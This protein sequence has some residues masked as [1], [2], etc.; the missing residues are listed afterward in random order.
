MEAFRDRTI[1]IDVPYNVRVSDEVR[2]YR[3]QFVRRELSGRSVAPHTLEIAALWAVM[4]RLEDPTHPN[5][6]LLQ[7][8]RLY[9]GQDVQGFGPEHVREMQKAAEREGMLGISPRYVQDRI[10]AALVADRPTVSPLDVLAQLEEG[11]LHH[12][13]VSN[14]DTRR[15]YVQLVGTAREE[16][17]EIIKR[18]VQEAISSDREALDRMCSKYVENVKA[19]IGREAE[20][21]GRPAWDEDLLRQIEEKIDIPE[22]RKHD[23][24]HEVMNFLTEVEREGR[25]FDYRENRRLA[26][27]LELKMFEDRRDTIQLTSDLS[28]VVDPDSQEKI[29]LIRDRLMR[30]CGYDEVAADLVLQQVAGLFARGEAKSEGAD[31]AEAA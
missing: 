23:F 12:S 16:Y 15:R 17:E 3:R 19:F 7:K 28:T 1:K 10:A 20:G 27:A 11:L 9:D 22:A 21:G 8:A 24:R 25:T 4:T 6:G 31:S 30:R 26:R 5:L 2:I 13:L 18:E 29:A 14:E